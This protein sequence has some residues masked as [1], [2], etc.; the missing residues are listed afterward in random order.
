MASEEGKKLIEKERSAKD[1]LKSKGRD[2]YDQAEI[3]VGG[4]SFA[5]A[6]D[7]ADINLDDAQKDTTINMQ[8]KIDNAIKA[9]GVAIGV[10]GG[11]KNYSLYK[12]ANEALTSTHTRDEITEIKKEI[13]KGGSIWVLILAFIASLAL[14]VKDAVNPLKAS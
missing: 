13:E 11:E 14:E 10:S 6:I 8:E 1:F 5:S 12:R 2:F 3:G 7:K 9:L 4:K